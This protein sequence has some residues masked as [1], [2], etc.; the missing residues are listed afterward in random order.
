LFERLVWKLVSY[1]GIQIFG[2]YFNC[3]YIRIEKSGHCIGHKLGFFFSDPSF[4][5]IVKHLDS[6]KNASR[7]ILEHVFFSD[8]VAP[9]R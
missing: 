1:Q 2:K 6:H 9:R 7:L 5:T 8:K 3:D 4:K